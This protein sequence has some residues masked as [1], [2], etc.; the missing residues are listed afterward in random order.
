MEISG[1]LIN[2]K[3]Y[4][5]APVAVTGFKAEIVA[6]TLHGCTSGAAGG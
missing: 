2:E 1:S 6:L 5:A 3:S 4:P